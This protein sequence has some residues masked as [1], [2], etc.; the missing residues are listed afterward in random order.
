MEPRLWWSALSRRRCF[1][2]GRMSF[3][4]TPTP[5]WK[6]LRSRSAKSP[7]P[8]GWKVTRIRARS[9][10]RAFGATGTC[11]PRGASR[12]GIAITRYGVPRERLSIA[13]YAEIAPVA[14]NDTEEGR[15]RNRRVD[16]V[17]LN[18]QGIIGE[19]VKVELTLKES[20]RGHLCLPHRDSSRCLADPRLCESA[21]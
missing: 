9:R 5:V 20:W 19:P 13:G 18:E 16:I 2:P 3:Q 14:C 10:L 1:H 7:T 11:R 4:R 8:C 12:S 6:K 21:S 15:A 17:I